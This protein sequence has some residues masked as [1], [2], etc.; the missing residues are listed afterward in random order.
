MNHVIAM[1]RLFIMSLVGLVLLGLGLTAYAQLG[2][3]DSAVVETFPSGLPEDVTGAE[4]QAAESALRGSGLIDQINGGQEWK[5]DY[6]TT[7][8]SGLEKIGVYMVVSWADDVSSSGPWIALNCKDNVRVEREVL[9][10]ELRALT[11]ALSL[12]DQSV[13]LL[14]PGAAE[15]SDPEHGQRGVVRAYPDREQMASLPPLEE[16]P[17]GMSDD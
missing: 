14:L 3:D 5:V 13:L 1:P 8:R 16:C 9:W 6:Y 15:G 12:E 10:H 4:A 11:V 7:S 17:E 2:D